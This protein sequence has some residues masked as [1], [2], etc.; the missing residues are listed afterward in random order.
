MPPGESET[1]EYEI[2]TEM[3]PADLTLKLGAVV[4]DSEGAF[5][6]IGAFEG[7][8]S[9]VERPMSVFDPQV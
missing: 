6:T 2:K 1:F 7:S 8:V 9:V 3:H 5:Y 4:S